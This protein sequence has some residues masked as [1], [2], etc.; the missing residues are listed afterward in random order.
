M[1]TLTIAV[2]A[3]TFGLRVLAT[4][5]STFLTT[6]VTTDLTVAFDV[7][8]EE[9]KAQIETAAGVGSVSV[10]EIDG[11]FEIV[12]VDESAGSIAVDMTQLTGTSTEIRTADTA[13][14][15]TIAVSTGTVELRVLATNL[16]IDPTTDQTTDLT[17]EFDVA[18]ADL[19]TQIET[20]PGVGDVSVTGSNGVFEIVFADETA[21]ELDA[22]LTVLTPPAEV[23]AEAVTQTILV[24]EDNTGLVGAAGDEAPAARVDSVTDV[25]GKKI[26]NQQTLTVDA[27]AGSFVLTVLG[28]P[29]T[30]NFDATAAE[31]AL[32][33]EPVLNPNNGNDALPFTNN[34]RVSKF[35]N[36]FHLIFQGEHRH[37]LIDPA[38]IDTTNL[39]GSVAL[40]HRL[41]G[42][43][44]YGVETLNI[45]FGHGDDV[46]NVQG[47]SATTNLRLAAGDDI[48]FVS[49]EAAFDTTN[50]LDA[51]FLTG[52]LDDIDGLLNIRGGAG[53]QKL[54]I[55]DEAS[56]D[57]N[58]AV[59]ITDD[60]A[61][62]LVAD[63]TVPGSK[64]EIVTG[65]APYPQVAFPNTDSEIYIIG[66]SDGSITFSANKASD[67]AGDD[68]DG[69]F[70][71][72]VS[73]FT[74]FGADTITI[75]GTHLREGFDFDGLQTLT[76]PNTGLGNDNV[77]VNL[78][79]GDDGRFVLNTQGAYDHEIELAPESLFGGDHNT[80]AD[81]VTVVVNGHVL[82]PSVVF[83]NYDG[84]RVLL[85][86]G[87]AVQ[88]GDIVQVF[89]TKA[90]AQAPSDS[91]ALAVTQDSLDGSIDVTV[92]VNG[93]DLD[94]SV[95]RVDID[96]DQIII[97]D[98]A[99]I[100][101]GD[102]VVVTIDTQFGVIWPS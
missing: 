3:G 13:H 96:G 84:D 102:T 11:S 41:A 45:N 37:L 86:D 76:T 93:Q 80:P 66:L 71:G 42:I 87:A 34:F 73:I 62:A 57:D 70:I 6:G 30:I 29:L 21:G 38:D 47:T 35:G 81:T 39:T 50:A 19:E 92:S 94:A 75:D 43:S 99:L 2:T 46:V 100:A 48:I 97:T 18:A 23:V 15:F 68:D 91:V 17:I 8:A 61:Q 63:P 79:E 9:L 64:G 49:N 40:D 55:S 16:T 14:T 58:P 1:H 51:D 12:F 26:N 53:S 28:T 72:G 59:L 20:A 22:T 36:V 78:L 65:L 44:Y 69:D 90:P 25:S 74:G 32:A 77:T 82:D 4:D 10:T 67:V 89:V 56:F 88:D 24:E 83:V 101:A 85:T 7:T 54:M 31:L 52:T 27:I 98:D 95:V 5:L 33:L 60:T